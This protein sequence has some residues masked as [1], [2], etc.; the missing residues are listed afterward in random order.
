VNRVAAQQLEANM[1][2]VIGRALVRR[3]IKGAV[4]S[5]IEGEGRDDRA[6]LGVLFTAVATGVERAE[7][8]C[9]SS[10][11]AQFQVARL[12]LPEGDH[13]LDLGPGMEAAV[14]VARGRGSFLLVLRPNPAAPGAVLVDAR[15]RVEPR[16]EPAPS[17]DLPP[18]PTPAR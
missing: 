13:V 14:R 12:V 5:A 15:S 7:T 9:W 2:G 3:V 4:G 11:P 18:I 10:L 6:L 1:P 16:R 17:K 8:R